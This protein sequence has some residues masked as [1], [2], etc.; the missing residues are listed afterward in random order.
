MLMMT[1]IKKL[2][3]DLF[4]QNTDKRGS[5]TPQHNTRVI[6]NRKRSIYHQ[7]SRTKFLSSLYLFVFDPQTEA[8]FLAQIIFFS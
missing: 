3:N 8:C 7:V 4:P 6:I 2:S 1:R 5:E